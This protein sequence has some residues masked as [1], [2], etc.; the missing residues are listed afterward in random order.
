MNWSFPT[1]FAKSL[2]HA[3][4]TER[5]EHRIRVRNEQNKRVKGGRMSY[6]LRGFMSESK[7]K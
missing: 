3:D 6:S 2:F 1:G 7:L 5:K 4:K